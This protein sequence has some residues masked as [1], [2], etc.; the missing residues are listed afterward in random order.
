MNLKKGYLEYLKELTVNVNVD[1]CVGVLKRLI[2]YSSE[3]PFGSHL[4][5][6]KVSAG[7]FSFLGDLDKNPFLAFSSF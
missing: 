2:Y 5:K 4:A 3:F 1:Y 6:M 7:L